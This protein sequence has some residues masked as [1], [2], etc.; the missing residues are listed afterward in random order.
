MAVEYL[1]QG[2]R[3]V[4]AIG[5]SSAPNTYDMY[6]IIAKAVIQGIGACGYQTTGYP[7][8]HQLT[9][10]GEAMAYRAGAEILGKE[11]VMTHWTRPDIPLGDATALWFMDNDKIPGHLKELRFASVVGGYLADAAGNKLPERPSTASQYIFSTLT[12]EFAAHAGQGPIYVVRPDGSKIEI[13]GGMAIGA[14]IRHGDG[15]WAADKQCG[16]SVPGLYAAGDALGTIG[17]GATY[18]G[19]TSSSMGAMV[20][21]AI[22]GTAAAKEAAKMDRPVVHP[23]EI[24]R[25]KQFANAPRERK[26]GFGPRWVTHLLQNTMTPYF[27]YFIKKAD[28]LQAALTNIEFMQQHLVPM[29]IARDPHELR[30]AHETR[31][32]VL[33]AE[34]R[35]RSALFR[36]ESRGNHYREDF[37]RRDDTN[38][39]AWTKIRPVDGKMTMVK[40]P[41]PKEWWQHESIPY[42]QRYPTRF[43]GE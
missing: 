39:L 7:P 3:I 31:S 20:T 15:I 30:L 9:G 36:N 4:G 10:D 21:G 11:F 35:L 1:K 29:L 12:P 18:G 19:G 6:T 28:R 38:W 41:I 2:G 14:S 16:S 23:D 17:N 13:I 34:F 42:E 32:M 43:P 22:A 26:G 25:A 27:V 33:S 40:V 37:P 8:F 24:A 5:I